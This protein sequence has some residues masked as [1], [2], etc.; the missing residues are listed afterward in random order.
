MGKSLFIA[1]KPS[2]A[3]EFSKALDM[4]P[5]E[6]NNG[7]VE[8]DRY[9]VTWCVGHL[10][11]LSY[12]D[13]YD[14]K[15][16]KWDLETLPFIPKE[17]KYEVIPEVSAQYKIVKTLLNRKDVDRIYYSGD[18]A[19]EGEY[20]QRLVRQMAGHNSAAKEFRVWIDSQTREEILNGIKNA[21]ELAYYDKLS[22]SAYARAIEDYLVGIDFSR[23]LSIK[24]ANLVSNAA[25]IKYMPIA[26]G[27]VMSCV[28]GMIV[29]RERQ[30]RSTKV[31]PYYGIR[32][33]LSANVSADWKIREGSA[34]MDDPDRYNDTGLL[35]KEK[36]EA[37][38]KELNNAGSTAIIKKEKKQESKAAP[39]LFNLAELQAEC[40]KQFHISP[41]DTLKIAQ[42]LYE[43]KL[44]TYPRTDAR[45]L[46][47]AICKVYDKNIRG[48]QKVSE[49]AAFSQEVLDNGMHET[50]RKKVT[51]YV[52]DSKVSDHYAIIPTGEGFENMGKL[53]QMEKDVYLL[54]CRRFLSIFYPPAV[55]DK[56][57]FTCK[58]GKEVFDGSYTAVASEGYLKVAG[59]KDDS[60]A[61]A[62]IAEVTGMPDTVSPVTFDL[63]EGKSKPPKRYT[64]GSMILAMENAG[65]LIEDEALREQIK[66]SGIGTS[67]TRAETISKLERLQYIAVNK[68]TQTIT[69][70]KLGEMIYDVLRLSVPTILK[71][72][73]TASWETGLQGIVDGKYTKQIYLDKIY[74]YIKKN[75]EKM[76]A[77]NHTEEIRK[78]IGELKSVYP[79]IGKMPANSD[80]G[81]GNSSAVNCPVCGKPLKISEKSIY[82]SAYKEGC[83]FAIWREISGKKLTDKQLELL[84]KNIKKNGDSYQSAPSAKISGFKSKKGT[85]FD[86]KL[87]VTGIQ[88]GRVEIKFV[89]ENA[90]KQS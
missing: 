62:A 29:E 14:E 6:K 46:T 51:K 27:R 88:N 72:D 82:C 73:Y 26:V 47:T 78:N 30:I 31:I 5:K 75:T 38:L 16:K 79:D 69:P 43:A 89:F 68:K 80:G 85:S 42:T 34:Y 11:T 18:S 4:K 37:L 49:V 24:Y 53:S 63:K 66:G 90:P 54:I 10:V 17:Y 58:T 77:E 57:A 40:T 81:S 33:N 60:D 25:G 84:A 1:E 36:T 41:A 28:L 45:V 44:T 83:K 86:A 39:L 35:K 71:P 9:I 48:L 23:A 52:D 87:Q 70:D 3:M 55:Y 32:L 59:R 8:D 2:V 65:K 76:K 50:L 15:L 67:A 12:P 61:A 21:H 7:F 22:D 19:R 74:A 64:T 13:K 20:I 56:L